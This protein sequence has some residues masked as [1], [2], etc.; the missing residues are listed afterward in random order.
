[1]LRDDCVLWFP[2]GPAGR[3]PGER[4]RVMATV[5]EDVVQLAE[6]AAGRTAVCFAVLVKREERR[7]KYD[8]P[9]YDCYFRAKQVTRSTKVWYD[10]ALYEAVKACQ[11]GKAYRLTG[12]GDPNPKYSDNLILSGIEPAGPEHEAEGYCFDDLLPTSEV[13]VDAYRD[14]IRRTIE[15]FS[16]P[17]LRTLIQTLLKDNRDL[18]VKLPAAQNVHHAYEHGLLEHVWSL[19][20]VCTFLADHYAA[21]YHQLN[22]PLSKDLILAAAIVHDIGKV[23]EL[24]QEGFEAKYTIKGKLLGHIVMGRDMVRDAA[25][26]IE[27]FPEETLLLLEHAILAHH[28]CGEFGSPVIPLTIEALILSLADDLDSKV[29]QVARA[30]LNSKTGDAFTEKLWALD[31][32]LIYKG[33]PVEGPGAD[34]AAA[35]GTSPGG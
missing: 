28:G 11:V 8:K 16:D 15:G 35:D 27:G 4:G 24:A 9:F 14:Y 26:R 6:L 22:P 29:N 32:R 19:T 30:R 18:F 34:G 5:A 1:M 2:M 20:R 7:T 21:Y 13:P 3:G 12:T 10:A 33:I 23:V 17:H 31:N 25:R